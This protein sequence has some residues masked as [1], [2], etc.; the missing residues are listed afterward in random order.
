MEIIAISESKLKII[1]TQKDMQR[2]GLDENEFYLSVTNTKAILEKILH[3]C[4][5]K[6]GFENTDK[7]DK[8]LIQLYPEKSGG[9][10]LFVTKITLD[11][12]EELKEEDLMTPFDNNKYLLSPATQKSSEIKKS[13]LV[14]NFESIDDVIMASRAL[15]ARN[16]CTDSSLYKGNNLLYYLM[17]KTSVEENLKSSPS[18]ILSEFGELERSETSILTLSEYGKCIL[19]KNAIAELSEI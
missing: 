4:P 8:I 18:Y 3:N 1:M 10:E 12:A 2:Y 11:S 5:V 15:K 9:C 6:T 7:N 19:D 16:L 17:I 14:Y 13:V